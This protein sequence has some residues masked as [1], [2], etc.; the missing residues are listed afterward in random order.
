MGV[1]AYARYERFWNKIVMILFVVLFL[2]IPC[3]KFLS[4]DVITVWDA[5]TGFPWVIG[6]IP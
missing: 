5:A 1:R 6:I 2:R 4:S 3:W